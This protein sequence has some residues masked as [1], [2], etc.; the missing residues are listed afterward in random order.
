MDS[1]P[2]TLNLGPLHICCHA[3]CLFDI[4]YA[5]YMNHRERA[6]QT[7][8]LI[9][10]RTCPWVSDN[11]IGTGASTSE[12]M[13]YTSFSVAVYF[14]FK[15]CVKSS[16]STTYIASSPNSPSTLSPHVC[17]DPS[18]KLKTLFSHRLNDPIWMPFRQTL[19]DPIPFEPGQTS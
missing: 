10:G 4:P 16:N 19:L 5:R 9:R 6:R 11:D 2:P 18:S 17:L 14:Q 3:S 13:R 7:P 8:A 1:D 15:V 12:I